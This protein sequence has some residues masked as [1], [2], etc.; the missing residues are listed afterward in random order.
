ML[1]QSAIEYIGCIKYED[2]Y[3][4]YLVEINIKDG[5]LK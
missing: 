1:Y 2:I 5:L 4:D 3:K